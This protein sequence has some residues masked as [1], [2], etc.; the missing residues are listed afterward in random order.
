MIPHSFE[1]QNAVADPPRGPEKPFSTC[2]RSLFQDL[3][4][5]R[6]LTSKNNKHPFFGRLNT[7]KPVDVVKVKRVLPYKNIQK[8]EPGFMA[9]PKI[10]IFK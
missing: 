9:T 8:C 10:S 5:G 4:E 2:K 7:G 1:A 6:Y 3:D